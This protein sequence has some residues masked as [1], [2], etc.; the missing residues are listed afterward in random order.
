[1]LFG[2]KRKKKTEYLRFKNQSYALFG[3][4]HDVRVEIPD[5]C[6][7]KANRMRYLVQKNRISAL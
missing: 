1:V 3:S 5:I 7:I 2:S 6:V 4:I